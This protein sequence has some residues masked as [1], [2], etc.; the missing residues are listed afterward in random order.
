[1]IA[2]QNL[3]P[4]FKYLKEQQFILIFNECDPK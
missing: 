4:R 1:M 3:E 2:I